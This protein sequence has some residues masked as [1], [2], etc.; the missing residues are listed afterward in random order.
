MLDLA[1]REAALPRVLS[2]PEK[3]TGDEPTAIDPEMAAVLERELKKPGDV[4]TILE[5]RDRFSVFRLIEVKPDS[6]R[7]DAVTFP[8]VDFDTWFEKTRAKR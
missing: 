2:P 4:T 5:E 8:K 1:Q 3:S 7:V 6:W